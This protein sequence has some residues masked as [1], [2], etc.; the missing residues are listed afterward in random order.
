VRYPFAAVWAA[1]LLLAGPARAHEMRPSHLELAPRPDGALDVVF[2]VAL[3]GDAVDH[4]RLVLPDR[5][6]P[7]GK[8]RVEDAPKV[9]VRRGVVDCGPAGLAGLTVTVEGLQETGTEVVVATPAGGSHLL[10]GDRPS[11]T[12][13]DSG[14]APSLGGW[15]T[16]G[17]EHILL[18]PDHLAFVLGLFLLAGLAAR[19]QP[20]ADSGARP[21]RRAVAF[22][23]LTTLTMFTVA[24]SLTLG[25]AALGYVSPARR[26]V[27]A[28][29]ALSILLLARELAMPATPPVDGPP[30]LARRAPWV[31]AFVCGLLHGFGFAGALADLGL[32][33]TDRIGALLVF[34][35]GVEAGQI[36]FVAGLA[37][38]GAMTRPA[39][40]G[41]PRLVPA[42]RSATV[43]ALGA[44][45]AFWF[46]ERTV[47]IVT[48][49]AS[50]AGLAG[51]GGMS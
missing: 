43:T 27:E 10:R 25:L 15:F 8:E 24:H 13:P 5:C 36:A 7:V 46:I 28:I 21:P 6:T 22:Q 18:G 48:A 35:L 16:L 47:A 34:N 4:L 50:P 41:M 31:F 29:I 30:S 33:Q 9:V 17:V 40:A 26:A 39:F 14:A 49:L 45:S 42:L 51:G 3:S 37:A 44:V 1:L 38:L 11:V 20:H 19:A 23:V 12:L 2:R 32:P